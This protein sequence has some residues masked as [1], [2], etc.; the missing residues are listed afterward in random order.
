MKRNNKVTA[1][2][3]CLLSVFLGFS[4]TSLSANDDRQKV[5]LNLQNKADECREAGNKRCLIACNR[6]LVEGKRNYL[7]EKFKT[8]S[9]ECHLAH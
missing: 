8:L 5:L 9:K 4:A 1:M 7:S 3:L 2:A 6:A